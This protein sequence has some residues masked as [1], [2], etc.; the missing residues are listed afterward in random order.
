MIRGQ[1]VRCPVLFETMD[2][3]F[4]RNFIL[5]QITAVNELSETV[6]VK[7]HDLCGTKEIYQ[8]IFKT[9][10]TPEFPVNRVARCHGCK[11][12]K[13]KTPEGQGKILV[14]N[15]LE[16]GD[17]YFSYYIRLYNGEIKKYT[18]DV[19]KIEYTSCDYE[20][21]EQML[22]YEFQNPTWYAQRLQV[23]ENMHLVDNSM[24][25]FDVI[26]GC[27][28]FLMEHQITTIARAFESRP[29]RYMLADE[30]GLG[31]TIE[32]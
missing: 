21:V 28:V 13:V 5:A 10:D 17:V 2:A 6:I 8:H 22:H 26:S 9:G 4:P 32:V 23:S 19:L 24:Y 20:P 14:A 7:I 15:P 18:E 25:G 16:E 1:Y 27:R 31:K 30:V 29:I 11:G 3:Q 12:A